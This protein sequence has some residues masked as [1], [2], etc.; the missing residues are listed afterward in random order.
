MLL[1]GIQMQDIK[2]TD[3]SR[4]IKKSEL[5]VVDDNSVEKELT[6]V[7]H[8][9]EEYISKHYK[10]RFNSIALDVES[11]LIEDDVWISCNDDTLWVDIQKK[12]IKIGQS[13]LK[14]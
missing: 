3:T 9:A 11:S 5:T 4:V 10:L 12:G 13:A 6:T 1:K 7:F 14:A 2:N 8:K